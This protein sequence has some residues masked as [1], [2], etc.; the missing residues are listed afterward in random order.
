M[1]L[2]TQIK[3]IIQDNLPDAEVI[4]HDPDGE[5]VEA[6]VVSASFEGMSL[7]KQHQAVMKPLKEAFATNLHAL[8]LKTLTPE[9]WAE[10]QQKKDGG[11]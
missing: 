8:A 1:S 9:K 11:L 7:V 3:S 2:E 10:F 5:H 6:I 4:V